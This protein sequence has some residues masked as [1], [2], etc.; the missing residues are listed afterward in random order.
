M[1]DEFVVKYF[2]Y[3][4]GDRVFVVVDFVV[5][6]YLLKCF[7]LNYFVIEVEVVYVV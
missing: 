3:L 2:V 7:V 5:Y 4:Y 6:S 1:L